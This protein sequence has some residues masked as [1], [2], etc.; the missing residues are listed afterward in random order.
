[1]ECYQ[2]FKI[3]KWFDKERDKT[4]MRQSMRKEKLKK[5][6]FVLQQVVNIIINQ[7]FIFQ[8][9]SQPNVCFL[10]SGWRKNYLSKGEVGNG[11]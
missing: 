1:M 8:A 3:H 4:L 6:D 9:H 11:K 5:V 10:I 7:F 2:S